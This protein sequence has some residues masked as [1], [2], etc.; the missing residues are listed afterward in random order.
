MTFVTVEDVDTLLGTEWNGTGDKDRAVLE[1]NTYLSGY[2]F[3]SW[4]A[5]PDEI[6]RAGAE[7]AKI[8]AQG[9]LYADSQTGIVKRK[10]VKADTVETETEFADGGGNVSGALSFVHA[11]IGPWTA[12]SGSVR[13]LRRL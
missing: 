5:Q 3:K 12:N 2:S 9:E 7:L 4:E 1:A 10:R 6:T 8:S 13:L 11:L